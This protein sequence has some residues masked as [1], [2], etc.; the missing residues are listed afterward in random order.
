MK[1]G[2]AAFG[3]KTYT[4]IQNRLEGYGPKIVL[5]DHIVQNP[6]TSSDL[7]AHGTLLDGID[8]KVR[9]D[10]AL[11]AALDAAKIGD[12]KAFSPGSSKPYDWKQHW[13]MAASM[14]ATK[15]LGYR[16]PYRYFLNERGLQLEQARP[17]G[18]TGGVEMDSS[19]SALFGA[20]RTINMTA[21]HF[22]I[23]W[24]DHGLD[25]KSE[26]GC[27]C[28]VHIDDTG[29]AMMD[30]L[31]NLSI[32]PNLFHHTFNELIIKT[33]L[34]KAVG[35]P[36]W[37]KDRFNL[38]VLSPEMNYE[39]LGVSFDILKGNSYRLTLT[40][41]CGLTQ[42]DDV[43]WSKFVPDGL[44]G[45]LD[46]DFYTGIPTVLKQLSPTLSFEKSFTFLDGGTSGPKRRSRPLR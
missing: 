44:S 29:V 42:C 45:L 43:Q 16:E 19:F 20:A 26:P 24:T 40:A 17:P 11:I 4:A 33:I 5:Q 37:F 32:T 31:E 36:D 15:G 1:V 2:A 3:S 41:S 18:L 7:T 8:F 25:G 34:A 13:A 35:M 38:H 6:T 12:K 14:L 9:N 22:S 10:E 27:Y 28:N 39:R 23:A 21:L 30:G 46:K